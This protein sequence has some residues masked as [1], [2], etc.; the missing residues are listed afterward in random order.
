MSLLITPIENI[1][2]V[3]N[4]LQQ[5]KAADNRIRHVL[6]TEP[7]TQD[8]EG[9]KP[10]TSITGD[11]EI[12]NLSFKYDKSKRYALQNINLSIPKGTSWRLSGKWEAGNQPW[13][14]YFYGYIILQKIQSLLIIK[15]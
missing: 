15:I 1:G 9:V 5:G 13:L 11:I 14:T 3:I 8:E 4:L 12:K 7:E 6:T 2:K 10:I